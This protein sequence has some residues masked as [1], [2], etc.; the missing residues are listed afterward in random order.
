MTYRIGSFTNPV[1]RGEEVKEVRCCDARRPSSSLT[2]PDERGPNTAPV[3]C[4]G[5]DIPH[6]LQ[7]FSGAYKP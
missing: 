1:T 2:D 3:G 4:V 7:F 6:F 5:R